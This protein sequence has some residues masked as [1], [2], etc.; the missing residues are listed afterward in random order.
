M[1]VNFRLNIQVK[2][3]DIY[4]SGTTA[5]VVLKDVTTGKNIYAKTVTVT[6]MDSDITIYRDGSVKQV[7]IETIFPAFPTSVFSSDISSNINVKASIDSIY[8]KTVGTTIASS[9]PYY[10]YDFDL[11]DTGITTIFIN[12]TNPI[13]FSRDLRIGD[14]GA[15]VLKLKTQLAV[16][17]FGP[18]S[19]GD[20]FDET[21]R[22]ALAKYQTSVGISPADG[23]F[24]PITRASMNAQLP[25]T[26]TVSN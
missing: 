18:L 22:V 15:D 21:T 5:I 3:S 6:P 20:S 19:T 25:T 11:Y 12:A 17:G 13:S 14:T 1:S 4:A 7:S 8:Y 23:N 16:K 9:S 24:G 2:G 26:S 10:V